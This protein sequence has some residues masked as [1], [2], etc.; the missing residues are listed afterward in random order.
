MYE[1][2]TSVYKFV[3]FEKNIFIINFN[4]LNIYYIHI[5]VLFKIFFFVNF[6]HKNK[7]H[8]ISA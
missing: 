7:I 4:I 6:L 3:F 1:I 5:S 2:D 8:A